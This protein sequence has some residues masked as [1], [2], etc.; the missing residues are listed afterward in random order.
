MYLT[1]FL[2]ERKFVL[3]V[4]LEN[5]LIYLLKI[6]DDVSPILINTE[7]HGNLCIEWSDSGELLAVAGTN[8]V[9]G[10][11]GPSSP[12]YINM[13]KFYNAR[14]ILLHSS[15]IPF[16]QVSIYSLFLEMLCM[17]CKYSRQANK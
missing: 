8:T 2:A 10:K 17:K 3:A 6:F 11:F 4:C 14:G 1:Y 12:E 5:G 9:D 13:L 15:L 16:A 7:L